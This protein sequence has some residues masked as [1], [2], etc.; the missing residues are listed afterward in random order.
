MGRL[1]IFLKE[2]IF[3]ELDQAISKIVTVFEI[4]ESINEEIGN[5]TTPMISNLK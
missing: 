3:D 5:P 2:M 4:V 1:K